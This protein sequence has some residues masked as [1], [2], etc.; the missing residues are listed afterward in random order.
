MTSHKAKTITMREWRE[1]MQVPKVY[2]AFMDHP[3]RLSVN[4]FTTFVYGAKFYPFG[5]DGM[6]YY[7]LIGIYRSAVTTM[8]LERE[9]G[10]KL[11]VKK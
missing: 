11:K 1:I 2:D 3:Q 10:G 8:I 5:E 4:D 7:T 6:I 9:V